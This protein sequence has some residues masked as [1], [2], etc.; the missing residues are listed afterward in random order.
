M[1]QKVDFSH[2][3]DACLPPSRAFTVKTPI[4]THKT[5]RLKKWINIELTKSC[6]DEFCPKVR[7]SNDSHFRN[8]PLL[9]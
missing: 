5:D 7:L 8:K 1:F 6:D 9:N 4:S 2:V 3:A